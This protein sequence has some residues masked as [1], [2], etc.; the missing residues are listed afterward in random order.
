[1]SNNILL[2]TVHTGIKK[3]VPTKLVFSFANQL[4]KDLEKL[5]E[6][7]TGVEKTNQQKLALC[8]KVKLSKNNITVAQSCLLET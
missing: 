4:W 8:P 5:V 7:W 1:M 6:T 3:Q 2:K